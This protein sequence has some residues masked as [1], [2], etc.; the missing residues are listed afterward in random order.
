MHSTDRVFGYVIAAR[1][2]ATGNAENAKSRCLGSLT[3]FALV[4]RS[5]IAILRIP[6]R[7]AS[8]PCRLDVRA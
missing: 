3:E 2:S 6:A 5:P 8:E 4:P 7:H 1:T